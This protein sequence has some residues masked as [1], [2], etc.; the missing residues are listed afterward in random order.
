[1]IFTS[2]G[3]RFLSPLTRALVVLV[4]TAALAPAAGAVPLKVTEDGRSRTSI[5][6]PAAVM[7]GDKDAAGLKARDLEAETQRRRLRESVNDLALYLGKMSGGA[8]VKIVPAA[9]PPPAADPASPAPVQILVGDLAA[10][11]FGPPAKPFAYKQGFRVVV[12]P[13][14]S[15]VGLIGESD[16]ATSYAVFEILDRLGCRW[17]M[18][19][20]MGEVI[21]EVKT[22]ALEELDFSS[23]PGTVYRGIW[24]ADD[25]YMRRN[26]HGGLKL[27]AGHALE[28]TGVYLTEQEKQNHPEWI[29]TVGGK[30]VPA[31]L[32]WSNKE[33]ADFIGDKIIAM[34][35]ANPQPSYSLSP[36][37][38]M[39][40]DDSPEDRAL[41]AGDFDTSF[42][43]VSITDRFMVLTNRIIGRV[44]AKHPDALF[45]VLAYVNYTRPP[46][47]EK[48]HPNFVPQIAPITYARAHPMN[49][50]RVPDNKELR[51]IVE[52]WGAKAR[53]TSHYFYGWFLAEPV[54]PN[55]M[56]RKWG[57]DIPYVLAKGN[58]QFWQPETTA[59]FDTS[60]HALYMGCRLAWDPKLKPE[61]V[62]NEINGRFYGAAAKEMAAY[63]DFVDR[64]WVETPEYAGGPWGHLRRWTPQNLEKCRTLVNAAAAA[65]RTPQEKYRVALADE[66]LSLFEEFMR[67]RYDLAAGRFAGLDERGEA[68]KARIADLAKK[69]KDC[70]AF[71]AVPW[72][73]L[74]VS[75]QYFAAFV[76]RAYDDAARV[77]R[78]FQV[79]TQPPLRQW[80]YLPDP[81]GKGEAAGYVQADFDDAAWKTTDVAVDTWSALGHHSY[82]GSMWYRAEIDVPAPAAG[83]PAGK[84]TY[85]WLGSTDG[86]AKVFVNGTHVP[87]VAPPGPDGKT[88]PAQERADG[89]CQP[90]S[91]DISAALPPTGKARVAIVCT[92][93]AAAFNELG[94]G[95]LIGPVVVYRE[96]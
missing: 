36:D 66:S 60:M 30:P 71:T 79:L 57:H 80:K 43:T 37:D 31:R 49:D 62:V 8:E 6:A 45:G 26:R 51:H 46:V 50:D 20:E 87:Y 41:D 44:T 92:R 40:F 93:S 63:W 65:A 22:I 74:T 48:V 61:D 25:A 23:H 5:Y 64:T 39:N 85:L 3:A 75:S 12:D 94:S 78:D 95:G 21:P 86:S 24:Y 83:A 9:A 15:R 55:P 32:K 56:I 77:A 11:A 54:A 33:L 10:Q 1:M 34:H 89:Y 13:K 72:S 38:G 70:Y 58:C 52:G 2:L 96:K 4:C 88:P 19:G 68:W 18:P 47:R 7:E 59:N 67:L 29:A 14:A 16:L 35:E 73:P 42:Q 53:M 82:F 90:F 27:S 69:Y 91:F 84:K 17:F 28:I 81:D 76:E